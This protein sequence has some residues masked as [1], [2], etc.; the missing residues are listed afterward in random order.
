MSTEIT[1]AIVDGYD[2][3]VVMGGYES[4]TDAEVAAYEHNV[5]LER[6]EWYICAFD[7][8]GEP[9]SDED[10]DCATKLGMTLAEFRAYE[11]WA[12][13]QA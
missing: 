2:D 9:V 13:A 7:N 8:D 11:A 3:T 10:M 6:P 4:D 12:G 5:H 1:F